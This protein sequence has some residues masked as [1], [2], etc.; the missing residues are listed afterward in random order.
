MQVLPATRNAARRYKAE[1]TL[2]ICGV[3]QPDALMSALQTAEQT[4]A[5][6]LEA[7]G[8]D[9]AE[10]GTHV[11]SDPFLAGQDVAIPCRSR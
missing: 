4:F 11:V 3:T 8:I 10:N 9:L 7:D 1:L 5:D 6:R 2:L